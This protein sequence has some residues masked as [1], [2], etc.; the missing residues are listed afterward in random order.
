MK[1]MVLWCPSDM[2]H[3]VQG[4]SSRENELKPMDSEQLREYAHKMVVDFIADYYKMIES[5]PVL[6]QV[7]DIIRSF[8]LIRLPAS[9]KISKM[10]STVKLL[11]CTS[12]R[13]ILFSVLIKP[14]YI[15]ENR[16]MRI[17]K[18]FACAGIR[19]KII[20][21]ITHR[22]SPD[23]FAY[24][25]S[26]RSTAGF[27]GEMLSAGFNIVGFSWIASPAA[28]ELEMIVLGWFA[29]CLSC[30]SSSFQQIRIAMLA[31]WKGNPRNNERSY[32]CSSISCKRQNFIEGRKKVP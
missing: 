17:Q 8:Y 29:K 3:W 19:Q 15:C 7:E 11:H 25:P 6:S 14:S 24:Y 28:T 13:E 18:C 30:L 31:R 1:G 16:D 32:P 20:P 22:Q 2:V 12:Q 26:N 9:L 5:F 27:L 23:Y 21:G 4:T 10:F